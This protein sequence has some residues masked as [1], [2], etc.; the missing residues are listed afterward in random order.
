MLPSGVEPSTAENVPVRG[1]DLG[2]YE[3]QHSNEPAVGGGGG[4]VR[5]GRKVMIEDARN[6]VKIDPSGIRKTTKRL[7]IHADWEIRRFRV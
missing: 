1:R 2:V 5:R 6:P 7:G 4:G 3:G